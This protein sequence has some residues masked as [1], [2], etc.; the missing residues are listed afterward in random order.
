[1]N[2]YLKACILSLA[3]NTNSYF[4]EGTCGETHTQVSMTVYKEAVSQVKFG[5]RYNSQI[6]KLATHT[7]PHTVSFESTALFWLM[8]EGFMNILRELKNCAQGPRPNGIIHLH[9]TSRS[10]ETETFN[11]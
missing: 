5:L 11:Q 4:L 9:S 1:M 7:M 10:H 6:P 8:E 3:T 2:F